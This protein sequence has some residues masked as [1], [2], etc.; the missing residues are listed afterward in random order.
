MERIGEHSLGREGVS[1]FSS[2]V[3]NFGKLGKGR[4]KSRNGPVG[5]GMDPHLDLGI[6]SE[7]IVPKNG[8]GPIQFIIPVIPA[9]PAFPEIPKSFTAPA[10]ND[11]HPCDPR[12]IWDPPRFLSQNLDPDDPENPGKIPKNSSGDGTNW[13]R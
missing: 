7:G 11:P 3:W 8:R 4:D 6:T 12:V 1:R 5:F 9:A 13:E 10:R 2:W